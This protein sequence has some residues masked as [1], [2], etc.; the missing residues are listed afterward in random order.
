VGPCADK[1]GAFRSRT[2]GHCTAQP[3]LVRNSFTPPSPPQAENK[4]AIVGWGIAAFSAVVVAEW[5]IH[6]PLFDYLLGFPLQLLGLVAA[7]D[8]GIKYYLDKE[9]DAMTD[10]EALVGKVTKRLPGL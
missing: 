2:P 4:V 6:L 9:S 3:K 7:I 1:N 5:F 8:L 10:F